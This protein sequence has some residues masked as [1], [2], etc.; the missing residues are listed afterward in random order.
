MSVIDPSAPKQMTRLIFIH[1]STG[2]NW[3]ADANGSLGKALGENNYYVSDTNYG[4][5][6]DQIGSRT[7][8]GHWWNW[9]CAPQRS[10]LYLQAVFNDGGQCASYTRP[11]NPPPGENEIILFKSCF[12]NSTLRGSPDA[13][14]PPIEKNPIRGLKAPT[15]PPNPKDLVRYLIG[16][17]KSMAKRI[18]GRAK[19]EAAYTVANAKGIYIELLKTFREHPNKLFIVLTAP[20]L[21][22]SPFASNTRAFNLWLMKEWL[23]DYPLKNVAVYDFYN[24]LTTNGGD[25]NTSDLGQASGNHHRIWDGAI[26]HQADARFNLLAYPTQDDHTNKT[27][28][29]KA[30]GEFIPVLN[31][32]YHQWKNS[33]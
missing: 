27:G 18:L 30:T 2:A 8:I 15:V 14:I 12:P 3:L 29:L 20:P 22:Y 21:R 19:N 17:V 33:R 16:G 13:P 23:A 25:R 1:H 11:S 24:V 32:F 26:Q 28:N 7:D 5:G 10:P 9:F 31:S 4:W 6:P